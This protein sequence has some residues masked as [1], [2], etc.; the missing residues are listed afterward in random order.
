GWRPAAQA[1]GAGPAP[2]W[3]TVY[4]HDAVPGGVGFSERCHDHHLRLL[5]AAAG[6]VEGCDCAAGCPACVGPAPAGVDARVA[7]RRLLSLALD[8]AS[9]GAPGP[10]PP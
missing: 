4:L 3:P 8:E 1:P 7:T 5:R 6:I 10:V 2:G 9:A